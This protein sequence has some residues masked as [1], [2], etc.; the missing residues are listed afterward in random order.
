MWR[1]ASEEGTIHP[2]M[3]DAKALREKMSNQLMIDL[4]EHEVITIDPTPVD[5]LEM[6][7]DED[8]Q[9]DDEL[10]EPDEDTEVEECTVQLKRVGEHIA[11]VHLAK[12][13]KVPLKF[14]IIKR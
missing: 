2:G 4:E 11:T 12:G 5:F 10:E 7:K 8:D 6:E 3:V 9:D 13:Y 14:K 1:N